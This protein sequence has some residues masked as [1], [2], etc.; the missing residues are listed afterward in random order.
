MYS[1]WT[2][3]SPLVH[4]AIGVARDMSK[5]PARLVYELEKPIEIAGEERKWLSVIHHSFDPTMAPPGKSAV[6]V[7]Y[8]TRY[9]YWESLYRDRDRYKDEK[10]RIADLTIAELDKRWSGFGSQ[11]EVVD[12]PTPMTYVRY[13]GNWKG[14]PDGWYITTDNMMKRS[15]LRFLPGL[16]SFGMVG[17]WTA[18]FTGTVMAA[19]S[20]RQFVE[21][22]CKQ[23]GR[24]FV[25]SVR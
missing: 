15:V 24:R 9:D 4:V 5:E 25:T 13:T 20:G 2:P 3:V 17:Q 16:S 6:E 7:W 21:V 23:D 18:P 14:S 11:V 10:K 22:L 1:E 12:V 8:P 19:L